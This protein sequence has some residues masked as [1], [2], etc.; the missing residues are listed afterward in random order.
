M[1]K[2]IKTYLTSEEE[3]RLM[4]EKPFDMG[5]YPDFIASVSSMSNIIKMSIKLILNYT[6]CMNLHLKAQFLFTDHFTFVLK[7]KQG[8]QQQLSRI[9]ERQFENILP[10]MYFYLMFAYYKGKLSIR[11]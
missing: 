2:A 10:L 6:I 7:C 1:E 11:Y 4:C 8:C 3:C 9:G 5:W